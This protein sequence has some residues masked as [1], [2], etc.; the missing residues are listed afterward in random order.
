MRQPSGGPPRSEAERS[1]EA[2]W[3]VVDDLVRFG[4]REAC[5]SP[6]SRSTAI[7]LALWRHPEVD[8]HVHLDERSSAFFALGVAKATGRPVAVA[9]TSG[10]AVAELFPAV[11][12][13]SMS[14]TV[15]VL[16]TADR[17][18]EL[19]GV[20]ANQTIDQPGIFGSYVRASVDAPVPGEI[21]DPERWH[22]IVGE[23]TRGSM[24]PPPGPVHLNLP[25]REPLV[26]G[27]V[28]L[29][30]SHWDDVQYSISEEAEPEEVSALADVFATSHR[31]LLFAG[32]LRES[33][34]RLSELAER[35]RWPLLAEPTSGWRVPGTLAAG[36]LL[37]DAADFAARHVPDVVLQF[38][39]APTSRAGLELVRRAERLVILDPDH[40]VGDPHRKASLR[41]HADLAALVPE[42]ADAVPKRE[43]TGWWRSWHSADAAARAAA[44]RALDADD[45]AFEGRVA[46][47]LAAVVPDGSI[48]AVGSSQP[49]RDLDAF[50]A[51][52]EGL[53]IL[54]DRGASGID[55]FVS[56]V[57]GASVAERPTYGL[58][59]DLT[60]L[61]DVGALVW[62]AGRGY[63]AVLVVLNN[64][65]G[66]IFERLPQR[67]LPELDPLFVTPHGVDLAK[68]CDAS[69]ATHERVERA[70]EL[71]PALERV[72]SGGGIAVVEVMVGRE[73]DRERRAAV[74]TAV[75]RALREG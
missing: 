65:G 11:V 45:R 9:T 57:L 19:R 18:P 51:P 44:D 27:E 25:F 28:S 6:G 60:L 49:V 35:V 70:S 43:E 31:G 10:T 41:V 37:L 15:L 54:A 29:P 39:A 48:L 71:V 26:P 66:A 23:V 56:T 30:S 42:L 13:A 33:P 3:L 59:G 4:M 55:G 34:S 75:E 73:H 5:A 74:R 12:E 2:A 17:P 47:D 38:G 7:A 64:G 52:R 1:F 36:Q 22:E 67:E 16:L 40:V 14:R 62:A 72:A 32:S 61:H 68:I 24:G 58:L 53:G 8:L 63:Q 46:R 21:D 20:G 69:G 50:M